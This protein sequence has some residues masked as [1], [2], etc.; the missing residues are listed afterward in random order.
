MSKRDAC[1]HGGL[2]PWATRWQQ[3]AS[4]WGTYVVVEGLEGHRVAVLD[5]GGC[6]CGRCKQQCELGE[7]G[8]GGRAREA[9]EIWD[10]GKDERPAW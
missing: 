6:E 3:A 9:G 4:R 10:W 1:W 7:D 5:A 2:N 8:H